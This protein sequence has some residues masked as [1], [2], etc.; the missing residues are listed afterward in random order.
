VPKFDKKILRVIALVCAIVMFGT[1]FISVILGIKG[2][3]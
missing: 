3:F 1:V 2:V